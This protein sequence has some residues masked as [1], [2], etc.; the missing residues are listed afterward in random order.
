MTHISARLR[1]LIL[2]MIDSII[3]TFSVFVSY[4]ILQP[5]FESYS[6]KLLML[7][8]LSLLI[9]HHIFA[10]AFNL[11][12]RAWEYA[13]VG[14]LLLVVK[15]VTS[16]IVSTM[17]IVAIL[18]AQSP[19]IRLYFITWMM[20]L[21][22]IGGSRLCWRVSS[23]HFGGKAYNKKPTLVVGAGQGGSMLIR[24]MLKSVEMKLEPVLAVDDDPKKY[25][26]A[27]TEGVKVQGTIA[28]IP[29]LVKKFNI[30]KIIIAIPTV[31][32]KRLKEIN[33]ICNIEGVELLRMPN[34]EEVMAGEIEVN[35]LKKVEVEDLLGRDP[36]ELNMQMISQELTHKTILVTGAGGS[37]GSEICRQVC[38]FSPNKV[39][40]LGHG[41][42]SIYLIHQEL[43]K[44][45]AGEIEFEPVIADVQN[46]VRLFEVMNYYK[47]YAVYHAAAHKHVPLMEYNSQ[48]ALRN[49]VLGT[50]NTAEAA[51][52]AAVKK[53]VMISTDKAVNPP[54]VMGATKRVAEMVIQS[55]NDKTSQTDFVAVRFGNV[56][57]SRG[58]VIPL[59]KQQIEAGGP[60]TVT[61][62]EMTRYF[63]TIPEASRLVLQ[64]GA[65]AQGGEVFVLD[66]GKPVKIVDLARNLIRLSGKKEEDI[67]IEFSGIRPGEKLYE[68][69]LNEGEIHPEQVYEKIYR[70]KVKFFS[71]VEV[72]EIINDLVNNFSKEKIIQIANE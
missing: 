56:L 51:K 32:Q 39:V 17:I 19:F 41:E 12:H 37:I 25:K 30:K 54:N 23:K 34:I 2:I 18:T 38:K 53:F 16:S 50:K 27:I 49:N 70:G 3:V 5:Y 6:I 28:D 4:F 42:N 36:V 10:L 15:A 29:E 72:D 59:F 47:P 45:Y 31:N 69:L 57:G 7:S 68:E 26:I 65:L 60:V 20:H 24:Q 46:R 43:S 63:M 48:E 22:F 61:H 14:E 33:N 40:L 67:G 64:A 58:S 66:M 21:I 8:A 35:Q 52:H 9:S 44:Q 62:P 13:S 1:L 55:L 11:Y 71:R